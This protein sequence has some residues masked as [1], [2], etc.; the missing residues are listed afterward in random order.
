MVQGW[1]QSPSR[2]VLQRD[3]WITLLTNVCTRPKR[4]CG[5]QGGR[6]RLAIADTRAEDAGVPG[7]SALT[8]KSVFNAS[9]FLP[10]LKRADPLKA[11][12]P[13]RFEATLL[14]MGQV[15]NGASP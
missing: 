4:K 15:S 13:R 2:I 11:L 5:L 10:H 1:R 6:P 9:A 3:Q 12:E 8:S 7:S 14:N